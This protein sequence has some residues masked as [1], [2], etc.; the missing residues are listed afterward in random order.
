MLLPLGCIIS[1]IKIYIL[2]NVYLQKLK[3]MI[4]TTKDE[5]TKTKMKALLNRMV[6]Y[7]LNQCLL[8][9]V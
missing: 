5:D 2:N 9:K 8:A 7:V 6:R 1:K 4:K 3:K